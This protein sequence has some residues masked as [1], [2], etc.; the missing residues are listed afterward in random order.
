[1]EFNL[2]DLW[3]TLCDAGPDG[4]VLHAGDVH[5][6][7]GQLDERANRI[8]HHLETDGIGFGDNVGIYS[9]NRAE[10][11]EAMIACWKIGAVP[12]NINYRYVSDELRYLIDDAD[13]VAMVIERSFLPLLDE[14]GLDFPGLKSCLV[15]ED[16]ATHDAVN[17]RA[18]PYEE[19][20]AAASPERGFTARRSG[21]D[22][23]LLY[24]G[25]TTGMPKGV[26]WRHEDAF[27]AAYGGGNYY[28]PIS[29]PEDIAA[30][31]TE[32][33]LPMSNMAVGPLMHGGGQWVTFINIFSGGHA[34]IWTERSF[35]A[36]RVLAIAVRDGATGIAIIGDAMARPLAEA[37]MRAGDTLDTSAI[38]SIGSGGA[39]LTDP[40]KVQLKEAFPDAIISDAYGATETGSAGLSVEADDET[41]G[42]RFTVGPAT[43][44][45]DPETLEPVAPGS[46]QQGMLARTGRIPL[47][48]HKD[49]A[50]T[51][52]TFRTDANG[53]RWVIPGDWALLD[54]DGTVILLGRGSQTINSGGEKIHPE[55]VE[56]A[57]RSHPGV[58]DAVVTAAPDDRFGHK[59]V[60]LIQMRDGSPDIVLRDI[61][62]HCRQSIAGFKVPRELIVGPVVRTNVGKSDYSWARRRAAEVL[63]FDAD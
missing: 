4:M 9:Y 11:V 26:M 23:Y 29:Q 24:T 61:Q 1:M 34:V 30:N 8:A 20:A 33:G 31:A 5:L 58:H 27:F 42:R 39:P 56:Q 60:A 46:G 10:F 51:A 48:Y 18:T 36:D 37:K 47:G 45:L 49:E 44:V 32:P 22:L 43:S 19:A 59:V 21:D 12:V 41:R 53:T 35:D 7:R 13:L 3:E 14:S 40:V 2:A 52:E 55:E 25:G 38:F 6:T 17:I 50:K 15:L 28:E 57:C 63:G 62:D 16:G 54:D